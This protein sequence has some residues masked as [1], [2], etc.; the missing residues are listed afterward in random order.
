M[1]L[2]LPGWPGSSG[3]PSVPALTI[4]RRAVR[5]GIWLTGLV[6]LFGI[7]ARFQIM[8]RGLAR[9]LAAN[10]FFRLYALYE[11]PFLLI[12]GGTAVAAALVLRSATRTGSS[13]DGSGWFEGSGT[14]STLSFAIVGAVVFCVALAAGHFALHGYPL[15]MDEFGVDFQ[16][17]IFAHGQRSAELPAFWQPFVNGITP[18]F[19]KFDRT[20]GSW[21]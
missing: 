18:V 2:R 13:D 12:V 19:V 21:Q 9:P 15:S 10:V 16:S 1:P 8:L 3:D 7:V 17:R 6:A 11:L 20:A 5:W 14:P 4:D